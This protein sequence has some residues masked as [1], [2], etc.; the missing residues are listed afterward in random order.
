MSANPNLWLQKAN[1]SAGVTLK[2]TFRNI[3]AKNW[4]IKDD[5]TL[6]PLVHFCLIFRLRFLGLKEEFGEFWVSLALWGW[7]WG[8]GGYILLP[9]GSFNLKPILFCFSYNLQ[10]IPKCIMKADVWMWWHSSDWEERS[11]CVTKFRQ[12]KSTEKSVFLTNEKCEIY[13]AAA[14]KSDIKPFT[15]SRHGTKNRVW[16]FIVIHTRWN[17]QKTFLQCEL[18]TNRT[19][20]VWWGVQR[21]IRF[22]WKL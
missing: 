7:T 16:V 9:Q 21:H 5:S 8:H 20:T 1:I 4:C 19:L 13:V 3:E 11:C 2:L 6:N 14:H 15:G 22:V 12:I 17:K 10:V 18:S